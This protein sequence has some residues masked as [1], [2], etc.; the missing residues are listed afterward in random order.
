MVYT[1]IVWS[2]IVLSIAWMFY[3][4]LHVKHHLLAHHHEKITLADEV[5]NRMQLKLLLMLVIT[6][7]ILYFVTHPN[8]MVGM[9]F[10]L[11]LNISV[12]VLMFLTPVFTLSISA[13]RHFKDQK[14]MSHQKTSYIG[15][16]INILTALMYASLVN[17][18]IQMLLIN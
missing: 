8:G 5:M 15:M 1:I 17:Y 16:S 6:W 18:G 2:V 11:D 13:M 7:W 9:Q 10:N 4:S 14:N 12:V 3:E